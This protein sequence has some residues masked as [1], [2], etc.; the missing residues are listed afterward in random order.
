MKNVLLFLFFI[1]SISASSQVISKGDKV[2]SAS[3]SFG[4]AQ[5]NADGSPPL[6]YGNVSIRPA[7]A[8]AISPNLAFGM[9][10]NFG[11]MYSENILTPTYKRVSNSIYTG[12]GPFLKKYKTLKNRF[13]MI[14]DHEASFIYARSNYRDGSSPTVK[15]QQ[16]S[17]SYLFSPGVF[18]KFS[19]HFVGEANIGSAFANYFW[20]EGNRSIGVGANFLQQFNLGVS[21]IINRN[22]DN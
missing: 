8:W 6:N 4:I 9:R 16:Y 10:G 22:Q 12:A 2:F 20:S 7:F 21:Y 1:V 13:G 15:Q 18:Y 14:F 11:Y 17:I 3:F 19:D 5:T